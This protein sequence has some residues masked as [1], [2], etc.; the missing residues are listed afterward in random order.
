M[1]DKDYVKVGNSFLDVFF[2]LAGRMKMMACK[3]PKNINAEGTAQ[4]KERPNQASKI[5]RPRSTAMVMAE[6]KIS[7]A[8]VTLNAVFNYWLQVITPHLPC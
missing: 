3:A 1:W 5:S 8:I 2:T 6:R 4:Q 7:T